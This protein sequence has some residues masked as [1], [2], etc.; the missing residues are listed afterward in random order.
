MLTDSLPHQ[1]Q[2]VLSAR[3][4]LGRRTRG[5]VGTTGL[6][7]APHTHTHGITRQQHRY[8]THARGPPPAAGARRQWGAVSSLVAQTQLGA[9][10]LGSWGRGLRGGPQ[11]WDGERAG[12]RGGGRARGRAPSLQRLQHQ[13]LLQHLRLA[14]LADLP[15]QKHLVHDRVNLSEGGVWGDPA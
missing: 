5:L 1:C 11:A 6:L 12:R 15:G 8:S 3:G 10:L 7:G 13:Q 2:A 14:G 9:F 4:S